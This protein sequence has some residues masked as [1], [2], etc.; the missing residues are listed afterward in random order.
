MRSQRHAHLHVHLRAHLQTE[1]QTETPIPAEKPGDGIETRH[2][3]RPEGSPPPRR[4]C[5][6]G[7]G[8]RCAAS[9]PNSGKRN[10]LNDKASRKME[11]WRPAIRGPAIRRPATRG[12]AVGGR[13]RQRALRPR[14]EKSA[15]IVMS[16]CRPTFG[17]NVPD[18]A[19]S[20]RIAA[21]GMKN[22]GRRRRVSCEHVRLPPSGPD[23]ANISAVRHSGNSLMPRQL[24]V[25]T[26]HSALSR[27]RV[28]LK[29]VFDVMALTPPDTQLA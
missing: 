3:V 8:R 14:Q 19:P 5:P 13:A 1:L 26:R 9:D 23:S 2:A 27:S 17:W 22:S 28:W 21:R 10:G 16:L 4:K 29:I 20:R 7:I 12:P 11:V 24:P 6:W 18:N 25:V 15:V